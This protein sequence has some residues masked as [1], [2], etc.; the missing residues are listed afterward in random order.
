MARLGNRLELLTGGARDPP[1]RQRTLRA[2]LDWSYDLLDEGERSLFA[3]LAVF[4]G[5]WTLEGAEAIC[6][7]GDEGKALQHTSALVDKSLVQQT[8][9]RHEG[10]LRESMAGR[11]DEDPRAGRYRSDEQRFVRSARSRS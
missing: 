2:T 9:I 7:I 8:N 10:S 5:G 3:R 1:D 11:K 4:V 6:D